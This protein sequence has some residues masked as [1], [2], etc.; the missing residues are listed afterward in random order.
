MLK[1]FSFLFYI[2]LICSSFSFAFSAPTPSTT[3]A[4]TFESFI[5]VIEED[6]ILKLF[7][8]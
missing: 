1:L 6:Q 8:R 2:S 4:S 3:A 7:F 5:T